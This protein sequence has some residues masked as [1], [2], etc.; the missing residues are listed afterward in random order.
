MGGG[1][2]REGEG[3][4]G[5]GLGLMD[6]RLCPV[7]SQP[8][9]TRGGGGLGLRG[10]RG[11]SSESPG[12]LGEGWGGKGVEVK[13]SGVRAQRAPRGSSGFECFIIIINY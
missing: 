9:G 8:S 1:G 5:A 2:E 11:R 10:D 3:S 12:V 4:T 6:P 13:S 7:G